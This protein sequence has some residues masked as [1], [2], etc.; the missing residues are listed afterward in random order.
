MSSAEDDRFIES[1]PSEQEDREVSL[2]SYEILTYPADFTLEVLVDKWNKKE[3]RVPELQRG[4][5]WTQAQSSKLIES[6]LLGLPVPPVFFYQDRGDSGLLVVDGQ[7]RLRSIVY[8]FSGLFGE[9]GT[10]K[11]AKSFN[12]TGLDEHSPYCEVTYSQ[13]KET[14]QSAFNKLNNSVL[15]SFVMKQLNPA[16]DTSIFQVF[17]RLNTG[18]VV[19]QGQ[20][21]RN[22]LYF[23]SFNE[24]LRRLNTYPAWRH[25]VGRKQPDKRMRDIELILRFFAL[26][27]NIKHYQK[28]MKKFLND[29]MKA[30][31]SL[32]DA[33]LERLEKLFR[34]TV[35]SVVRYLG[36]RP[37][38]IHRGLNAAVYD[39]VFVAF[40]QTLDTLAEDPNDAAIRKLRAR[41][42]KL[43][44]DGEY[45]VWVSSHTTDVDVV[46]DRISKASAVLFG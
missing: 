34:H 30:N 12:L 18:G 9:S 7:Q 42:D 44:K 14:N 3:I 19:L 1:I 46:P 43:T 4:F 17:E 16:D 31:T 24:S 33:K 20:E 28:P 45:L 35:D 26:F 32:K 13:I 29:F 36:P 41:F 11:R 23:G 2:Q 8:F 40:A 15:R 22:C 27:N 37:F 10:G 6:F 38:H 25:I 39:S 5:V 21:I